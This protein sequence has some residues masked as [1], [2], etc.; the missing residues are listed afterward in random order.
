MVLYFV[1]DSAVGFAIF[2]LKGIDEASAKLKQIQSSIT[3]FSSF[4]QIMKF[5]VSKPTAD[6]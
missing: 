5:R 6:E 1:H 2:E 4:S 3:D